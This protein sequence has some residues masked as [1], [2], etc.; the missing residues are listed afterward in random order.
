L[1]HSTWGRLSSLPA[2]KSEP[3]WDGRLESLPHI[4][5]VPTERFCSKAPSLPL[6]ILQLMHI[7]TL[8]YRAHSGIN[9]E[10]Y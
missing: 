7:W 8:T 3:S 9:N 10:I 6:G 4:D 5:S 2:E 1:R